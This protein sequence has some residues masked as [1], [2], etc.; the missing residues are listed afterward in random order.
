MNRRE[1]G[2]WEAVA[3]TEA[4]QLF[5]GEFWWSLGAA[6]ATSI[7]LGLVGDANHRAL[8]TVDFIYVLAPL[9]GIVFAAF[10]LV[11]SLF[12]DSYL[13]ALKENEKGVIAFLRPFLLAIGI[14]VGAII[15]VAGYRSA[16]PYLV[17]QV[18]VA[19]FGFALFGFLYS[20]LTVVSLARNVLAHGV[21][22]G[23]EAEV[24][25]LESEADEMRRRREAR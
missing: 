1:F 11:I 24:R 15:T 16:A 18:E 25:K 2:F 23:E 22:R 3:K 7:A 17:V 9:L 13:L 6:F 5:G 14:M 10:A 4:G 12:S 21:A 8:L 19:L 20:L